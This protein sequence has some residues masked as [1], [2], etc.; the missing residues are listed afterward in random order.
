M[1]MQSVS[2]PAAKP[3]HEAKDPWD[4]IPTIRDEHDYIQSLRGRGLKVHLFG[5]VVPEPVDHPMIRPSINAL[6]ATYK[7]AVDDPELA[8]AESPY[9]GKRVNRFL[10]IVTKPDDLVMKNKMQ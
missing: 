5:Q 3:A 8:T 6:A 9:T 2:T 1:S 7:L 4:E 10:H